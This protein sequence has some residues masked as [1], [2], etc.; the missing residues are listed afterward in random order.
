MDAFRPPVPRPQGV[1]HGLGLAPDPTVLIAAVK[2]GLEVRVFVDLARRL[3]V[4]EARL[5]EVAGI[6]PTTLTRRKRAGALA[7]D[8][9]EHVL[10]I[11]ALL[12][13]AVRVFEDEADAADWLRTR[14]LALGG[15]TPLALADT[16]LGAREVDDLLGRLEHGVYS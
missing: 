16:E 10:R 1:L 2:A 15:V 8:E 13:R 6:A 7:P 9:G 11:A 12:E 4:S 3:G 5:A 14:N